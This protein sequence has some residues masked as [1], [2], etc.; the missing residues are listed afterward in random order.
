[1][2]SSAADESDD[3]D[4]LDETSTQESGR[5]LADSIGIVMNA[6]NVVRLHPTKVL[7]VCKRSPYRI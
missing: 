6:V 3:D 5:R 4:G 2:I 1:M 7:T